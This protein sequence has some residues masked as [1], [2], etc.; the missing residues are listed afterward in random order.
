[1]KEGWDW[2]WMA[3]GH[4][5]IKPNPIGGNQFL[6]RMNHCSVD[7]FLC[8]RHASLTTHNGQFIDHFNGIKHFIPPPHSFILDVPSYLP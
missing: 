8:T 1:M 4:V 2:L 3:D 6:A 5:I 7:R